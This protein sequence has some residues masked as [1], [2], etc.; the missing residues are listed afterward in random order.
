MLCGLPLDI[1]LELISFLDVSDVISLISVSKK[2]RLLRSNGS[3]WHVTVRLPQAPACPPY[4]DLTRDPEGLT[5]RTAHCQHKLLV[6]P[7]PRPVRIQKYLDCQAF[8]HGNSICPISGTD[9]F[10]TCDV[11]DGMARCW[12][13]LT[14]KVLSET[15]IGRKIFAKS[16]L[17]ISRGRFFACL[18]V[19]DTLLQFVATSVV[20]L[21]LEYDVDVDFSSYVN[22]R[23]SILHQSPLDP[24]FPAMYPSCVINTHGIV[25]I[26]NMATSIDI[27][28]L[29]VF[30]GVRHVI[31]TDLTVCI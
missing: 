30:S 17:P 23:L 16:S 4:S 14:G 3:F 13:L 8:A 31:K 18:L 28:A 10:L 12:N 20:V 5:R 27:I 7:H 15:F 1:L 2:L 22:V 19:A 6:S 26:V 9:L 24:A 25:G 21:N 11:G 29:N